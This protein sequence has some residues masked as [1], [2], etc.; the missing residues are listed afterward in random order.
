VTVKMNGKDVEGE[1]PPKGDFLTDVKIK[2]LWRDEKTGAYF[3]LI[4]I[5]VGG[6]TSYRIFTQKP[7]TGAS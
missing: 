6:I 5:P 1:D 3:R 4:K 7:A 2:V